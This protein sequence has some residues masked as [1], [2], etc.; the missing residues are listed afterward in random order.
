MSTRLYPAVRETNKK[1]KVFLPN[2]WMILTKPSHTLLP[3]QVQFIVSPQMTKLDV[4]Q[5]LE[6]IYNVP[7]VNVN[8]HIKMGDIKRNKSNYIIKEDDYKVAYVTLEKDQKFEF[9]QLFGESKKKEEEDALAELKS[10][11][12]KRTH[13]NLKTNGVPSWFSHG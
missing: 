9:P 5:Y 4:K 12:Q 8:T 2:F 6:K 10:N 13:F 11:Y 3:N 1:L 7:I